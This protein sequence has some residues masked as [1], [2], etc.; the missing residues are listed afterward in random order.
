[1]YPMHYYFILLLLSLLYYYY[2]YPEWPHRQGG[3]LACCGCTFD[4]AEV[5]WFILCTRRSGG[6]AKAFYSSRPGCRPSGVRLIHFFLHEFSY[7]ISNLYQR[8]TF[9]MQS[10]RTLF[11]DTQAW[12][13]R[14]TWYC[15][16]GWGCD[17]S[18]GSTVS[19]AI[20][21]SW[22]WLTATRSFPVGCFSA[23]LKLV[24]NWPHFLW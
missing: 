22:L 10:F 7:F 24:D 16:W 13:C 5:H 23:L 17:Q 19:D 21:R 6:T 2:L 14:R 15:P 4:S 20:V 3:C 18:I 1:M 11:A 8:Y 12:S 9:I